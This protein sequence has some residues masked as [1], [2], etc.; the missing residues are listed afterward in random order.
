MATAPARLEDLD[1]YDPEEVQEWIKREMSRN[2]TTEEVE[3]GKIKKFHPDVDFDKD[4]NEMIEAIV[5]EWGIDE[6]TAS[7]IVA[8]ES[9]NEMDRYMF[10]T[11]EGLVYPANDLQDLKKEILDYIT[12]TLDGTGC[13]E[14][15]EYVFV[16]GEPMDVKVDIFFTAKAIPEPVPVPPSEP[17]GEDDVY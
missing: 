1:L 16:D 13:I 17:T 9:Y 4:P 3:M 15:I 14:D 5:N 2:G 11:S 10:I 7:S 12:G 6:E 8:N